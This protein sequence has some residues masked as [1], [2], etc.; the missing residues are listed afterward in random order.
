LDGFDTTAP[1]HLIGRRV[2]LEGGLDANYHVQSP[3]TGADL[4]AP[5]ERMTVE[6]WRDS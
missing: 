2:E 5:R 4:C 1:A 3:A 6:D